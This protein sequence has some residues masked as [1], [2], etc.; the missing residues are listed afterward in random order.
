MNPYMA[1]NRHL[2]VH[3]SG[4]RRPLVWVQPGLHQAELIEKLGPEQP[5]YCIA[6]PYLDRTKP[7]LT[8]DEITSFHIETVRG[9]CPK[10]PYAIAASW[11]HAAIAFE[12]ASRLLREGE[13]I[14]ALILIDPADP[15]VSRT[16]VVQEPALFRVRLA[17][18]R[19]VFQ[20][21][22][23]KEQGVKDALAHWKQ[24]IKAIKSHQNTKSPDHASVR[25]P[26]TPGPDALPKLRN[27]AH[28]DAYALNKHILRPSTGPA[29]LLRPSKAPKHGYDYPNLRWKAL[30][31]KD[32]DFGNVPGDSRSIWIGENASV[33]AQKIKSICDEGLAEAETS[34]DARTRMHDQNA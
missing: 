18:A 30:F 8:F 3:G 4:N 33:L 11:A 29:T 26:D 17:L 19:A 34:V 7:P 9:L 28:A 5:V 6:R 23:M 1:R 27:V 32:L 10:G 20:L 31:T 25:H 16:P 12:M 21:Q 15:A 13:S 14:G 24:K 22:K 2:V